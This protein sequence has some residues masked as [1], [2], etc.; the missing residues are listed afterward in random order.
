MMPPAT[1]CSQRR[2]CPSIGGTHHLA[3]GVLAVMLAA[4]NSV[5]AEPVPFQGGEPPNAPLPSR[6]DGRPQ[7]PASME[8]SPLP[9]LADHSAAERVGE[10]PALPAANGAAVL[11]AMDLSDLEGHPPQVAAEGFEGTSP[12]PLLASPLWLAEGTGDDPSAPVSDQNAE[13]EANPWAATV[14]LYGYLPI[15]TISTTTIRGLE[16]SSDIT[17]PEILEVLRFA[18]SGRGS[19]EYGRIGLLAD[20]YY[21]NVGDSASKLVGERGLFE[22][23]AEVGFIQG[24]YDLALRYRF[25]ERESAVG[26]AGQYTI[27]P[28]GGIRLLH[29]DLDIRATLT[30]PRGSFE[31]SARRS[32]DRTWVQPL[33]GVQASVFVTPRL[34]A[35]LRGDV[36]GFG[37]AGEKDLSANAQV[38]VSYAVGNSTSLNLSY[39]YLALEWDNGGSR[40]NAYTSYQNGIEAGLKFFF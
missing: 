5:R 36:G 1:L 21:V 8:P 32:F 4:A 25:G 40:P 38:G 19:I 12:R 26:E 24:I 30:G 7:P 2:L 14:E 23:G 27:I 15:S 28:Y 35:F 39:R 22:A 17:L 13:P 6:Q 37:L 11:R 16:A 20:L 34:K 31:R 10:S 29:G 9:V 18:A 3:L 33:V